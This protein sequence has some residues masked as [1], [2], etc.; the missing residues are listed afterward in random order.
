MQRDQLTTRSFWMAAS[1]R[2][3]RSF[4]QGVLV[5]AGAGAAGLFA[6]GWGDVLVS[7][8]GFAAVSILTSV[9]A[10]IPEAP[11]EPPA[12]TE[13]AEPLPYPEPPP[14]PEPPGEPPPEEPQLPAGDYHLP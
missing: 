14:F 10:G 7:S 9:V 3:V 2:A 12:P 6:A 13:P 8:L 11:A 4:C 1:M 5:L